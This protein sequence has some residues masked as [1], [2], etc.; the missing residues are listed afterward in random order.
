[1][2]Y[3]VINISTTSETYI[4]NGILT[5]NK[6]ATC[7]GLTTNIQDTITVS[8]GKDYV[9]AYPL[10]LFVSTG[11]TQIQDING[12][13]RFE[14]PDGSATKAFQ[15]NNEGQSYP[16]S[17]NIDFIRTSD[18]SVGAIAYTASVYGIDANNQYASAS[19]VGNI[20]YSKK[21]FPTSG[22][23]CLTLDTL[24][25][26]YD[27]NTV[28]LNEIE[29][30]DELVSIDLNTMEYIKTKVTGKTYHWVDTLYLINY[31]ALRCSES[32]RHIV[33]R[34]NEWHELQTNEL[35]INDILI[36][37]N[38]EEIKITSIDILK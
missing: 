32:H 37:K 17:V 30:G 8:F 1:M 11:Y 9:P 38:F 35:F 7:T 6:N 16:Y 25:E 15:I 34:N 13:K 23:Y 36:N 22:I 19:A 14:F 4:A 3:E 31:G 18:T 21:R 2:K 24:I 20:A 5:H 26:K 12:C 27:G 33:K 10:V 29:I 28:F